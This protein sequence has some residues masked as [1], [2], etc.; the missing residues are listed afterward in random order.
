[1]DNTNRKI[2]HFIITR[3]LVEF[4]GLYGFPNKL[5]E[6]DYIPNG[7]RVLKK[8]LF[9]SLENQSC[10]QFIFILMIGNKVNIT[11]LKSLLGFNNSFETKV[12]YE[13]D[14][15]NYIRN[16]SKGFDVLISTR[17]DYDDCIYYDAVNDVRKSININKPIFLYGYNRGVYYFESNNKFYDYF[18][19]YTDGVW[20]TFISL[21]I[22]LNKVND[23]YTIYD[24]GDHS[25]IKKNLLKSYKSYGIKELNYEPTFFDSGDPKFIYV[26][27]K[28]SG[29]Y[30]VSINIQTKLHEYNFNLSK[31]YGK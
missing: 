3:F 4:Y 18:Y 15:K 28:F 31:F 8:Y 10:K 21:I 5:Y 22:I 16:M 29:S 30:N 26:R 6:N 20:S 2:I 9:P 1:M 17:I 14:I 19:N 13:K 12:I 7:I 27:Q 23:S 24:L 25:Y 11:Y